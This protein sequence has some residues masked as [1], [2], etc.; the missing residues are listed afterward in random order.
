MRVFITGASGYIGNAVA[1]AFRR[2][3][4]QVTGLV[5]TAEQAK[6]LAAAEIAPVLGDLKDPASYQQA[7]RAAE[8]LVHCAF[9]YSKEG[10]A[11]DQ[12]TLDA[13]LG[14]EPKALIYTSGVWVYG[15]TQGQ[16]VD[17][18]NPLQPIELAR[19][20]VEQEKKVLQA[21]SM[22]LRT[23]IIRPGVVY[24]GAGG[25][26]GLWFASA[27]KGAVEIVGSGNNFWSLIHIEDLARAYV[28]AAEKELSNLALNV[29]DGTF[30]SVKE[31]AEAAAKAAGIAGKV[32]S[33]PL[34]D[35]QKQLGPVWEGLAIDQ[36]AS[37]ERIQRLL[38]WK[39]FHLGF[40]EDVERYYASW[41]AD[42]ATSCA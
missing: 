27:A 40:I 12:Q 3:G 38:G 23:V 11:R 29:T 16:I 2:N 19:W 4:H 41:K 31:M 14:C 36:K 34:P 22:H 25:L 5:R 6:R 35:A 39:P 10:V 1:R 9:E 28:L 32:V 15:N 7:A 24:G 20:R 42:Q 13:F 17:E 30:H 8:A 37:S 18:S 26:T 33:I 21:T